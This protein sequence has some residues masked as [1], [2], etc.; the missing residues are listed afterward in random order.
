MPTL[1]DRLLGR[2]VDEPNAVAEAV[3]ARGRIVRRGA[4][5][6]SAAIMSPE[7]GK[8]RAKVRRAWQ[9][10]AFTYRRTVPEVGYVTRWLGNNAR[11]IRLIV[12]DRPQGVDEVVELDDDYDSAEPGNL[13]ADLVDA[14]IAALSALT[15]GAPS[16]GGAAILSPI[17]ANYETVGECY[18]VGR[19]DPAARNGQGRETWAVHSIREVTFLDGKLPGSPDTL[20]DG[21]PFPKGYYRLVTGEGKQAEGVDLDPRYTT[22]VR[23]WTADP[24]WSAEPDSPMR[25]LVGVCEQL[26]MI[27]KGRMAAFR[28]R[29]AGNGVLLF[30]EELSTVPVH[31]LDDPDA[32][33]DPDDE[34]P[35]D[36]DFTTQL[37]TPLTVDGSAAQVVPQVYRGAYQY[38]DRVRLLTFERPLDP[39]IAEEEQRLLARLGI[40][41]DVP[42]EVITG[43]ADTNHWNAWQ[44]SSDTF[45]HH[46][47]PITIAAVEALTLGYLRYRL[48]SAQRWDDDLID[49]VV[50]WYDPSNLVAGADMSA[51]ANDAYDRKLITDKAYRALRGI[52]ESAAPDPEGD[53][54]GGQL[55]GS[56]GMDADTLVAVSNIAGTLL[57][58]GYVPEAVSDALGLTIAHTGLV[59]VTVKAAEAP[60]A[61]ADLPGV[62]AIPAAPSSTDE[63]VEGEVISDE[64]TPPASAGRLAL[65]AAAPAP[66]DEQ[67][68]LSRRLTQIEQ[69]LRDRIAVAAA[70]AITR[71]LERAG[72][73]VRATGQ[74]DETVREAA[75]GVP[76]DR[77]VASVGR[78][79]VAALGFDEQQLLAE[80]FSGL[81]AQ[82]VEWTEAAAEEAIDTAAR[83]AGLDRS[84]PDV[85]RLVGELRDRFH[86]G[87][88]ESWPELERRLNDLATERLYEPD[89]T[90]P[91]V[92][93]LP[94]VIVP[95]GLVREALAIAGGL[96]A[97]ATGTGALSGLTSGHLLDQFIRDAGCEVHEYEW[98]YG[99]SARPF[100]PHARL[101]G[102]VISDFDDPAL[103]TAGTGHEWVGGSFAPGDHRGCHCDLMP[104]YADGER[105]REQLGRIAEVSHREQYPDRPLP[106]RR[107]TVDPDTYLPDEGLPELRRT[108]AAQAAQVARTT[109]PPT[110]TPD[111]P[112]EPVQ[113]ARSERRG[114]RRQAAA[115]EAGI[116]FRL[117]YEYLEA[118]DDDQLDDLAAHIA[119]RLD[120]ASPI[121]GQRW[122]D[123]SAYLDARE[124][125]SQISE[126]GGLHSDAQYAEAWADWAA[127]HDRP[128]VA[129]P[130][131]NAAEREGVASNRPTRAEVQDEYALYI[132]QF[133]VDAATYARSAGLLTPRAERLGISPRQLLAGPARRLNRHGSEELLAYIEENGP[134]MTFTQMYHARTESAAWAE[135][136]A[137]DAHER[138]GINRDRGK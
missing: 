121:E 101:D 33:L 21:S 28:S 123:L 130:R 30:P 107:A 60:E 32:P 82:Y 38:L 25:A 92:G 72:N 68:R 75:A 84:A 87:I 129:T 104:I 1:L 16:G 63:P 24:E 119:A 7:E 37:T 79:L 74:R 111:P 59:P 13:P 97:D 61:P 41:L 100:P 4:L 57:R 14:A 138:H 116:P 43:L 18:L 58:A 34:D 31:T 9:D 81:R 91:A 109:P 17:T 131:L 44:I 76:G 86:D 114:R 98:S 71:A 77:V 39:R 52:D 22:V 53:E 136:A 95:P 69:Q 36:R 122:D 48:R 55:V 102:Q 70:A 73:R 85:Q 62:P 26:L 126:G 42:P 110:V 115:D 56:T 12:G 47:E 120:D 93:E 137:R 117:T 132:E 51:A 64:V 125:W 124:D 128:G 19:Y 49:R 45:K 89:P 40:G 112:A 99:I 15:G 67:R 8:R 103:S 83:L 54:Q 46:Q 66:T 50:L 106:T 118:L 113:A 3:L 135:R 108:E 10:G 134:P 105:T 80:A 6:A 29:A 88:D 20:D 65:T 35:F 90:T 27:E 94:S 127:R 23:L 133:Y 5:V 11:H 96:A 78:A 2:P